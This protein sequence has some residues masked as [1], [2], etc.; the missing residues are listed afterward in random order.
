MMP[1]RRFTDEGV[2]RFADLLDEI[3][4]TGDDDV[5]QLVGDDGV[6]QRLSDDGIVEV[7]PFQNRR[8]A[9]EYIDKLLRPFEGELEDVER[10][11]GLWAWLAA[12]WMDAITPVDDGRRKIGASARWIPVT[13]DYR[14]YYRHL[15]AGP[16]RIYRAH[17][18]NPERAMAV[19]ATAVGSPG[20]VVEQ[21]AS[22]Q[23]IVSN[24]NLLEAI[25]HLYYDSDAE[26]L[27]RGAASKDAG[28]ARRL[29]DVLTQLDLTWD[30]Y[31]MDSKEI[32]ELLPAEFDRFL[33]ATG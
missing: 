11:Q 3:R 15:L 16:Y 24:K 22:R 33:D 30:I 23:E 25:T 27:K 7:V 1:L 19:L 9:A 18:D 2:S 10:D 17:R 20:E 31:G 12:I 26:E 28:G 29:A 21:F 4:A 6:T 5:E 32:L 8:E 14:K 13:N